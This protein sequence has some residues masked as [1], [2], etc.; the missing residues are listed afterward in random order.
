MGGGVILSSHLQFL[1]SYKPMSKG[2]LK[3]IDLVDC[4]YY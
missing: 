3:A 4:N 1:E 2:E